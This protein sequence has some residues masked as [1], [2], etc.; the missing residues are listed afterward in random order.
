MYK[1][2][3]GVNTYVAGLDASAV[4]TVL[5]ASLDDGTIAS[6]ESGLLCEDPTLTKQEFAEEAD[7]VNLYERF[8][9]GYQLPVQGIR[10]P[11]EADFLEITDFRSCLDAMREAQAS[12]DALP[13]GARAEFGHDP[14]AFL[15]FCSKAENLPRMH[16]LGL[17]DDAAYKARGEAL[18]AEK[19][20]VALAARE[21]AAAQLRELAAA[22]GVALPG[23]KP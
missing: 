4:S 7:I 18:A 15:E 14:Q 3:N 13:A 17:L 2:V 19:A 21:A 23:L 12:F 1:L 9:L 5:R 20:R 11:L 8:G 6:H 22:A 10:Q 16:E